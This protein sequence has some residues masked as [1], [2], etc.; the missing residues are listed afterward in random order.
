MGSGWNPGCIARRPQNQVAA[1]GTATSFGSL[2]LTSVPLI[3]AILSV[4]HRSASALRSPAFGSLRLFNWV[5]D[6]R[7]FIA[8]RWSF[9]ALCLNQSDSHL[10]NRSPSQ[11]S[12]FTRGKLKGSASGATMAEAT[13]Q[14]HKNPAARTNS[15]VSVVHW[16]YG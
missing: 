10:P 6:L 16:P 9:Y 8:L 3:V 14:P 2:P 4:A 1:S 5:R 12:T 15:N 13:E 7:S 11:S